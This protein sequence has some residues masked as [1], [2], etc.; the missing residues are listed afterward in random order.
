MGFKP[1]SYPAEIER[2]WKGYIEHPVTERHWAL[3]T[4]RAMSAGDAE[5]KLRRNHPESMKDWRIVLVPA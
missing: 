2:T 1:R 4:V 3:P 5:K